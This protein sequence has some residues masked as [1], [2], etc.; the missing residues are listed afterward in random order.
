MRDMQLSLSFHKEVACRTEGEKRSLEEKI[1]TLRN[2]LQ[3]AE[4]ESRV[5]QVSGMQSTVR[6]DVDEMTGNFHF[7][8]S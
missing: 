7:S 8:F 1:A 4:S 3:T 5:Q 6:I 2:S